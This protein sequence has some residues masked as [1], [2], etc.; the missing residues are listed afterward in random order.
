MSKQ[1]HRLTLWAVIVLGVP[2]VATGVV[3]KWPRLVG[4][5]VS[6]LALARQLHNAL[7]VYFAIFLVAQMVTGLVMWAYP[8]LV[9]RRSQVDK[10]S[11]I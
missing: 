2:Q 3:M 6:A 8:K 1:I 7:S 5:E 9:Q 11:E 4:S 10:Q